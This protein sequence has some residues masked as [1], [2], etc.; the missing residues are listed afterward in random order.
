MSL[1]IPHSSLANSVSNPIDLLITCASFEDR[2]LCASLV[3]PAQQVNSAIIF[4]VEEFSSFSSE[5]M[6]KLQ[7]H[8]GDK[9]QKI[10]LPHNDPLRTADE[11]ID[12]ITQNL[13]D[14]KN[15]LVDI[16]TFTRESLLVLIKALEKNKKP[17]QKFQIV[18]T[19]AVE[20][21]STNLSYNPIEL[22]SVMGYMGEMKPARPL[23]LVIMLGFEYERAQQVIDSYEPDYISI[24]HGSR[25]ESISLG[26]HELNVEFKK[27]L[28]SIYT[29]SV[30][31][32]FEHSLINPFDVEDMLAKIIDQKTDHNTVVVP[33]NNK[34]STVGAALLAIKRPEIQIC[35]T[36][37]GKYNIENYS[38]PSDQCYLI[39]LWHEGLE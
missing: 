22:R 36:Q 3:L 30:V 1:K 8:F 19:G 20:Y 4:F 29:G 24:G 28:I 14:H 2:C 23:H 26:S 7:S 10:P 25:A 17:R 27:K 11:I 34:I 35:Y 9:G 5:N 33:L 6:S 37:M 16:S 12:V 15:I 38:K 39:N 31:N 18:Y 32:E 13:S 21:D